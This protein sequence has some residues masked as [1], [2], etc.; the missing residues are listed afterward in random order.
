MLYFRTGKVK[1]VIPW[2]IYGTMDDRIGYVDVLISTMVSPDIEEAIPRESVA[3]LSRYRELWKCYN[4]GGD[5][6][7]IVIDRTQDLV[8]FRTGSCNCEGMRG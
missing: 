1:E 2:L 7:I 4:Q 3:W 8:I 5:T 6:T